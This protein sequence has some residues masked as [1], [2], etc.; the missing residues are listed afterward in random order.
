MA[1][2]DIICNIEGCE[3]L[4][5]KKN[6]VSCLICRKGYHAICANVKTK[7]VVYMCTECSGIILQMSQIKLEVTNLKQILNNQTTDLM[8]KLAEKTAE[9]QQKTQRMLDFSPRWDH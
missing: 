7:T 4:D 9:C 2:E 3:Q 8:K 1:D 6:T 5:D